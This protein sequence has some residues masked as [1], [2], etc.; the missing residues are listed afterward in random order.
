M[1]MV[2]LTVDRCPLSVVRK[3]VTPTRALL[4]AGSPLPVNGQRSTEYAMLA[5]EC[6]VLILIRT[7]KRFCFFEGGVGAAMQ[8]RIL[9]S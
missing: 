1:S 9:R 5:L 3:R 6:T 2:P 8:F 4:K 7:R